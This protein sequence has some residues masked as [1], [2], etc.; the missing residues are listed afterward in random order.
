MRGTVLDGRR[1]RGKAI[2]IQE[3]AALPDASAVAPVARQS[4][5][6]LIAGLTEAQR[7]ELARKL[8]GL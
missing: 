2:D 1:N 8:L 7:K 5:D 6:A 4:V 3:A